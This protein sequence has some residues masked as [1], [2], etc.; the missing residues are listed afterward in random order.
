L[1]SLQEILA[2]AQTL[3]SPQRAQLIAA[4]WDNVSP[5]DWVG[6]SNEW[7]TEADRRIISYESGEMTGANW[8]DV[9]ARAR[10]QAGLDD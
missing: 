2:A 4:L 3:P 9:R 8:T 6:P 1:T 5:E 10:R 7:L